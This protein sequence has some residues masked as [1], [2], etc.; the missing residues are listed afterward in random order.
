MQSVNGGVRSDFSL[1]DYRRGIF[2][3]NFLIV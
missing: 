2:M 1:D 3:K